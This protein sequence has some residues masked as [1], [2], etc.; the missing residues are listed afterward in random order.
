M[1]FFFIPWA[2][3]DFFVRLEYHFFTG[4]KKKHLGCW[5]SGIKRLLI[6]DIDPAILLSPADPFLGT[7]QPLQD[8]FFFAKQYLYV[9]FTSI[10]PLTLTHFRRGPDTHGLFPVK[11]K[12]ILVAKSAT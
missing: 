5:P 8:S 3:S 9:F 1:F 4:T 12:N 7:H 11:K 2:V 6:F 10:L